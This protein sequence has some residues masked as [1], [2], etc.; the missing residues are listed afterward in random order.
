VPSATLPTRPTT[1][2]TPSLFHQL[3]RGPRF[4]W[5][6]PL[7]SLLLFAAFTGL[8][9][10]VVGMIVVGGFSLAPSTRWGSPLSEDATNPAAML[11]VDL[12]L[13]S[14]ML[15]TLLSAWIAHRVRPGFL[16]SVTGRFRWRWL[17]R[18]LAVLLPLWAVYL[19]F[20]YLTGPPESGRPEHW[21]ILLVLALLLTPFQCAGEELV[22]RGWLTQHVGA[23]FRHPVVG[24]VVSTL[25]S[26]AGFALVHGSLDPW[27]LLDLGIFGVAASLVTWRTGGLESAIAIHVVNNVTLFVFTTTAGGYSESFVQTDSTGDPVA[28]LWTLGVQIVAVGLILWQARRAQITRMFIPVAPPAPPAIW[29]APLG[30]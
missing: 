21:V 29:I 4:R 26:A 20:S 25:V 28:V 13:A 24:L 19:T 22:F 2:T 6:R 14:L 23:Y 8:I 3:L 11:L 1:P 27:I 12:L 15:S 10:A 5:W 17:L 16:L 7:L 18:C 30:Y 9:F